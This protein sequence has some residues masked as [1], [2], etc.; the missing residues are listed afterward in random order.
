GIL[1]EAL[2]LSDKDIELVAVN[3]RRGWWRRFEGEGYGIHSVESWVDAI[4]LGEGAKEKLPEG[5][6]VEDDEKE[7]IKVEEKEKVVHEEL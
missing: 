1:K 5:V 2:K 6:V 3:G 7:E 4:R